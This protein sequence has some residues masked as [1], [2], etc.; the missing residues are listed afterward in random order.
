MTGLKYIL[1]PVK[2]TVLCFQSLLE[3]LHCLESRP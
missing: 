1:T 3:A 2:T